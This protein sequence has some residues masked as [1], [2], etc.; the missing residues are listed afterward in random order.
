MVTIVCVCECVSVLGGAQAGVGGSL[1]IN[2]ELGSSLRFWPV[3]SLYCRLSVLLKTNNSDGSLAAHKAWARLQSK[4][5]L[6]R[7]SWLEPK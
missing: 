3:D 7:H 5:Q 6:H 2:I 1:N 4:Y